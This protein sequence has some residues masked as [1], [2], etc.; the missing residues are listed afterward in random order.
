MSAR[1]Q[2][3]RA[4]CEPVMNMEDKGSE[5]DSPQ[6]SN[7]GWGWPLNSRKA[8]YFVDSRSLCRNWMFFG[9]NRTQNQRMG[10]EPGE[11][12]CKACFRAAKKMKERE[13]A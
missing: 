4:E 5:K 7:D 6:L 9:S 12:D 3:N 10:E 11:D 13:K 2:P 8:H 1:V